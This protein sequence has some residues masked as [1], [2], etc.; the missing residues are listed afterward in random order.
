VIVAGAR[1]PFGRFGGAFKDQPAKSLGAH[2]IRAA[3]ER[4]GVK[5]ADVDYVIMGQVLQAGAGQITARQA[6]IEAGV[7]QDVPAIT[8]NKVCLSGIN[9]IALADQL[10]RAGEVEVVVAGGMESMSEAPYLVPKARFGARMGNTEMVDS[11]VHDGL[12]S[13]FTGQHMGEGSD[14]VNRELEISREEQ[15]AWAARSHQRAA[16]AWDS[17]VMADEVAPATFH[18]KRGEPLKVDRDEGV[19]PGTTVEALGKLQPAF[20]DNGTITA[21]N[22]SQISDGAVAVVVMSLERARR[23]ELEP[24]ADVV[25]H[26]MSADRFSWLH[27]VPALALSNALKKAGLD[28]GDLDLVEINEAFAAVALNATRMLELD[29]ERVNVNGG[30]VALGHPIGASGARLVLTLAYE[31]KRRGLN[32]GAAAL[33]GG[34]GQGDALIIRRHQS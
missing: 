17:G 8:I 28:A 10:I 15:D 11:M 30:A 14:E 34:G 9:A 12:W 27:T 25:A 20:S 19:R 31:L 5:G 32:M 16:R 7:P 1:T 13:T 23:L 21:G 24:L 33:C 3:L 2:A 6:A 4:A 26:G 29:E 18:Q 22:A